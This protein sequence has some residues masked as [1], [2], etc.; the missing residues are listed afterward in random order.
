MLSE[1]MYLGIIFL[2]SPLAFAGIIFL[3]FIYKIE[4]GHGHYVGDRF[5]WT[6][7]LREKQNDS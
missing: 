1:S 6:R 7:T 5:E 3:N 4:K 2:L